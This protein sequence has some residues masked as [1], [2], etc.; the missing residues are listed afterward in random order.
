MMFPKKSNICVHCR[1]DHKKIKIKKYYIINYNTV[2]ILYYK[3]CF[4]FCLLENRPIVYIYS[5]IVKKH[6]NKSNECF[7]KIVRKPINNVPN[8]HK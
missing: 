2:I 7:Q 1:R 5:T 8:I 6:H 4:A 3:T